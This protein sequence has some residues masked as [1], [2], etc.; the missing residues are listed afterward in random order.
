MDS[1]EFIKKTLSSFIKESINENKR[2]DLKDGT[3]TNINKAI[4]EIQN[5]FTNELLKHNINTQLNPQIK[6]ESI[7]NSFTQTIPTPHPK[8][9]YAYTFLKYLCKNFQPTIEVNEYIDDFLKEHKEQLTWNDLV[10]TK[11]GATRCKTNIRFAIDYLRILMLVRTKTKEDKRTVC[12]SVLG[13]L[14]VLYFQYLNKENSSSIHSEA[15]ISQ[16]GYRDFHTGLNSLK[17]PQNIKNFL[18]Y[19][20]K[21]KVINH[22]DKVKINKYLYLFT[23]IILENIIITNMSVKFNENIKNAGEYKRLLYEMSQENI[24]LFYLIE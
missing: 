16:N 13:F 12:P 21:D 10:I 15:I 22:E 14:T 23:E 19:I 24:N 4:Y 2:I 20:N 8:E 5:H 7:I 11:T 3:E 17:D 18:E 9:H 6:S 1:T